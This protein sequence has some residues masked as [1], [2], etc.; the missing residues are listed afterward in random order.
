MF[1]RVYPWTILH[2]RADEVTNAMSDPPADQAVRPAS[3]GGVLIDVKVSPGARRNKLAGWL[4]DRLKL[5]VSAPPEDGKANAAVC[6]LMIQT[7]KVGRRDITVASG[8]TSPVKTLHLAASSGLD[9]TAVR[10]RL[11][12]AAM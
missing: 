10:Q 3:D 6:T 2:R 8:H 9:V 1:I 7:L 5:M 12:H 11:L 4:G